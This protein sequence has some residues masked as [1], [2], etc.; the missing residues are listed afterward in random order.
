M[1][2]VGQNISWEYTQF[3]F[4][5][6]KPNQKWA[7]LTAQSRA[8]DRRT[9]SVARE[10]FWQDA[11]ESV[12]RQLQNWLNS[13]WEPLEAVGPEAIQLETTEIVQSGIGLEHVFLWLLTLGIALIIQL[14]MGESH[15][16]YI[17]YAPKT[18]SVTLRRACPRISSPVLTTR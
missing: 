12:M 5:N 15:Q 14:F 6:W 1:I 18:F 7:C 2:G 3:T 4:E 13:G 17:C 16:R 8:Y 9:A 11:G 10:V